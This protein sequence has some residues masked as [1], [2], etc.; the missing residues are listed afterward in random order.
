MREGQDETMNWYQEN[1]KSSQMR[2]SVETGQRFVDEYGTQEEQ[3]LQG[4]LQYE[5]AVL[6]LKRT[7]VAEALDNLIEIG[8]AK[9]R[10]L[11]EQR[12]NPRMIMQIREVIAEAQNTK[13]WVFRDTHGIMELIQVIP[14]YVP[15]NFPEIVKRFI[16]R[17]AGHEIPIGYAIIAMCERNG[18]C[19]M[20]GSME[21]LMRLPQ[22]GPLQNTSQ[23]RAK[24]DSVDA[25]DRRN[26]ILPN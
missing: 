7:Q 21:N 4:C 16:A 18:Q 26:A 11:Q 14:H 9:L 25:G 5:D 19:L 13:A 8:N 12:I 3:D 2:Y 22:T 15:S 23:V 6:K 20:S 24:R 10:R 1:E 17:R